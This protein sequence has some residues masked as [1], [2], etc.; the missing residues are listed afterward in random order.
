MTGRELEVRPLVIGANG[1]VGGLLAARLE[2]FFP[3]TV[4][5]TKAEMDIT[6]RWRIEAELER[7]EPTL[8]V[9]AAAISDVDVCE[10]HPD[11]AFQVNADGPRHLAEACRNA[12][13]RLV[14]LSTDYVFSGAPG[15]EFDE[16]DPPD[17]VNLYGRTKLQGEMGVLETLPDAVVLRVSFIFGPGR[18]NFI[19]KIAAAAKASKESI[20]VVAGWVTKPT[21]APDLV[22]AIVALMTSRETGVWHFTNG[23]AA[24]RYDF[25]RR[26][27]EILSEDA[28]RVMPQLPESLALPAARP[29]NSALSTRRFQTRFGLPSRPWDEA[30]AEYL[31]QHPP[32]EGPSGRQ[33]R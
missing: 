19:D 21:A 23:P 15:V 22:E 33:E 18:P 25:A 13:I 10:R 31:A 8:V 28:S 1:M 24:S 14:H 32:P 2:E 16:S 4:S 7:I 11:L 30:A 26:V 27:F 12:K 20:P 3:H 29:A 6:D 9:N 17:P 5:A